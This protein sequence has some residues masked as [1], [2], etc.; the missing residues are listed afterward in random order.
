MTGLH[1]QVHVLAGQLFMSIHM[2][3]S[4]LQYYAEYT[5]RGA[6]LDTLDLPLNNA[7]FLLGTMAG[8]LP[9]S[10]LDWEYRIRFGSI[11]IHW[12]ECKYL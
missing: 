12:F 8:L 5:V 11:R 2:Q 7:P 3:L 10:S 9:W 6:N 4:V 1:A